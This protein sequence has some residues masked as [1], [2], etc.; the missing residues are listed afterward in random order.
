MALG[1]HTTLCTEPRSHCNTHASTRA[2]LLTF[3]LTAA[4]AC[5]LR[6]Q[7]FAQHL[8]PAPLS[9]FLL[10]CSTPFFAPF[11]TSLFKS[12]FC[13]IWI[14]RN[15]LRPLHTSRHLKSHVLQRL[16]LF[17]VPY[18]RHGLL[19]RSRALFDAHLDPSV[20]G[21]GLRTFLSLFPSGFL[22][23]CAL[24]LHL[25]EHVLHLVD[26]GIH[27]LYDFWLLLS[28]RRWC[29]IVRGFFEIGQAFLSDQRRLHK[30][31]ILRLRRFHIASC[32][33]VVRFRGLWF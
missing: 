20:H 24:L 6:A 17:D 16:A 1:A 9:L 19:L 15:T 21:V 23:F 12:F 5:F 33:C 13:L 18:A 30:S 8:L 31:R 10:L 29:C 22:V 25:F 28:R 2:K 32:R 27:V 14:P 3:A 11:F 7:H 4:H 26:R